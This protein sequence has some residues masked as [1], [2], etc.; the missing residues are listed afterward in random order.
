MN[1]CSWR[2]FTIPRVAPIV[3]TNKAP[4]GPVTICTHFHHFRFSSFIVVGYHS[5]GAQYSGTLL[6]CFCGYGWYGVLC[7]LYM[8]SSPPCA[9]QIQI[10]F[11]EKTGQ[12]CASVA[13]LWSYISL[14][15]F[16]LCVFFKV[17]TRLTTGPIATQ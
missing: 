8:G 16:L 14:R 7:V 9:S 10:G 17:L 11:A 15:C 12:L 6:F 4:P 1:A 13:F 5:G 3:M 2:G